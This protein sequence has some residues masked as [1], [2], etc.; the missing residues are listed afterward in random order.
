[1][2]ALASIVAKSEGVLLSLTSFEIQD[3]LR[4]LRPNQIFQPSAMEGRTSRVLT[5]CLDSCRLFNVRGTR[6]SPYRGASQRARDKLCFVV[7]KNKTQNNVSQNIT[8]VIF[9]GNT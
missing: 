5:R 1:M 8:E 7:L 9:Y 6:P 4:A 2:L 3:I